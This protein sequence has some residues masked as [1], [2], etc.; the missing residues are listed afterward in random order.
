ME[1]DNREI[2]FLTWFALIAGT[3]VWKTRKSDALRSLISAPIK[4]PI[5]YLLGAVGCYVTAC[6]WLLSLPGWW[7]WSNLKTSLLWTGGF[8]LIAVF[9]FEKAASGKAY[10]RA[11]MLE[12]A[13]IAALFSFIASSHT[14]GLLTELAIA[15]V[16]IALAVTVAISE[17]DARLKSAH[18]IATTL[19]ILLSLLM[20]GNSIYHI[21][22]GFGDFATSHT[23]REFTLPL[24]LTAMFLPFLYGL[25]VYVT[26]D[27]V[28]NSFDFSIKNLTLHR[29]ARRRLITGFWLDTAGL[30]KW[31]RHVVMFEPKDKAD[32]DASIREIKQARLRENRPYRVP[33]AH[34]WLPNHATQFLAGAGLPTND[35]HRSHGRWWA[36]SKYLDIGD[37]L[38]PCNLAY[39]VEGEEF[40][41]SKLKLVLNVNAPNEADRAYE[42]FFQ[43]I[44]KLTN[45]AIPGALRNGKE[46]EIRTDD[47]PLLVNG[48]ALVLRR[49]EWPNGMPGGHELVF[50]I[51]VIEVSASVTNSK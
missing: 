22:T 48:Y 1:L 34:G 14:F 10:F 36:N 13:G 9:N 16:W 5:L 6:V 23:A 19:L 29:Y 27:R 51:E 4:P 7:Q 17:R 33:P 24:L 2:A 35:Y 25:Y 47:L 49:I 44:S 38:L 32:I 41:V 8:A 21:V 12:A 28:L 15:F 50:T 45:A 3:V 26:Y 18:A 11:T 40:V 30:E 31:R 37:D 20:L 42:Q 43:V 46:L 39:Y